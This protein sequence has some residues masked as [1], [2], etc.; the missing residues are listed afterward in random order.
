MDQKFN[1]RNT[2]NDIPTYSHMY[3]K[4]Y[5]IL[6]A[7]FSCLWNR[8]HIVA[9]KANSMSKEK[10]FLFPGLLLVSFFVKLCLAKD[11]EKVSF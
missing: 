6:P 7:N 5:V 2:R 10:S 9:S 4:C 8:F 11:G 1:F 3:K